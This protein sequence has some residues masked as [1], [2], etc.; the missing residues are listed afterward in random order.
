M[1]YLN[2]LLFLISIALS[3]EVSA[4]NEEGEG[5]DDGRPCPRP[6]HSDASPQRSADREDQHPLSRFLIYL[7]ERNL[8]EPNEDHHE[9]GPLARST[10]KAAHQ[11]TE[12]RTIMDNRGVYTPGLVHSVWG[13]S[14]IIL[15]KSCGSVAE[16][17]SLKVERIL[18]IPKNHKDI[19]WLLLAKPTQLGQ[20]AKINKLICNPEALS[21]W[22]AGALLWRLHVLEPSNRDHIID[23]FLNSQ[24]LG[25]KTKGFR[26]TQRLNKP[27]TNKRR[28]EAAHTPE[29]PALLASFPCEIVKLI[30]TPLSSKSLAMVAFVNKQLSTAARELLLVR[31]RPF[32]DRILSEFHNPRC[33]ETGIRS[34][35]NLIS[36]WIY[37]A[38]QK[39]RSKDI[40]SP[41][42]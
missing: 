26:H 13:L 6:A 38:N 14:P 42:Q 11:M 17:F 22:E 1:K 41:K 24:A 34:K 40:N 15:C 20:Y 21:S 28:L 37:D 16:C 5:L 2:A 3:Q 9:D 35:D 12:M 19:F 18:K 39:E 4:S 7:M 23:A 31:L 8:E 25:S 36:A 29:S 33:K 30:L 27:G 32:R 10:V